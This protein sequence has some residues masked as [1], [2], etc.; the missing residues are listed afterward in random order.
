M[1][2]EDMEI[3]GELKIKD[4]VKLVLSHGEFKGNN[5]IDLRQH[6]LNDKEE[7]IVTRKGINFDSEWVDKFL[8]LVEKLK[9]I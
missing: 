8:E 4:N 3:I 7:W 6:F 5:R 1:K 2:G 9:D